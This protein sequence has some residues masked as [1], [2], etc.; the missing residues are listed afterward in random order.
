MMGTIFSDQQIEN[1]MRYEA[2]RKGGKYNMLDR[3]AILA[4]KLPQEDYFFVMKH[5]AELRE[6]AEKNDP[7]RRG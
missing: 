3:F 4:S 7:T 6:A 1:F 5:F 2:V